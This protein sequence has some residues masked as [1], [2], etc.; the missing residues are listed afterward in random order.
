MRYGKPVLP[1]QPQFSVFDNMLDGVAKERWAYQ[2][3]TFTECA[4][5]SE[6]GLA[7]A[8]PGKTQETQT[9]LSDQ[10]I[11]SIVFKAMPEFWKTKLHLTGKNLYQYDFDSLVEFFEV[12]RLDTKSQN[13]KTG[14]S[15]PKGEAKQCN[16]GADNKYK[17]SS[18]KKKKFCK[19]CKR[20]NAPDWVV[21]NHYSD[22]CNDPNGG[23]Y[24]AKK[25]K[26]K[27]GGKNNQINKLMSMV[28]KL[29]KGLKE[30]NKKCH[31][32]KKRKYESSSES[33]SDSD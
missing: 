25:D 19:H 10:E 17:D 33:S 30:S 21:N 4:K 5:E 11:K 12:V 9:F 24:K 20:N 26:N 22:K 2:V 6:G 3:S 29:K 1:G 27:S 23:K 14:L 18:T 31:K 32:N 13:Q 16:Q 7:T 8:A 28:G 15:K